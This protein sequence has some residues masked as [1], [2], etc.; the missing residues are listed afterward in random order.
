MAAIRKS[1]LALVFLKLRKTACKLVLKNNIISVGIKRRKAR[2]IGNIPTALQLVKL[3]MACGVLS[4]AK[5]FAYLVGGKP[6]CREHII[7]Q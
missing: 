7:E 2:G 6:Q 1:A 5:L 4:S 3:Y